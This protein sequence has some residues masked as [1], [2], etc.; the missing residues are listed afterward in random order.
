M[1]YPHAFT[2]WWDRYHKS[3]LEIFAM[4]PGGK[5]AHNGKKRGVQLCLAEPNTWTL[6]IQEWR[7]RVAAKASPHKYI[8]ATSVI[9]VALKVSSLFDALRALHHAVSSV[10][11]LLQ[12]LY[13]TRGCR[14]RA[15]LLSGDDQSPDYS[16]RV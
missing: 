3:H 1:D 6:I 10:E 16:H 13:N 15:K 12:A 7:R 11:G 5:R 2:D 8:N 4:G 14:Y 9:S